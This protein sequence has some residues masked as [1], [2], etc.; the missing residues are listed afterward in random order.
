MANRIPLTIAIGDHAATAALKDGTVP[1]E[2]VDATFLSIKPQIA[3]FRRM[4]RDVEFDVCELAATTYV[5][6]RSFGAPFVALPTFLARRFHHGELLVRPDAGI[7]EPRDLEGRKAGVRA[8]SVTTGV[9]SRGVLIEEFGLHN[10]KVRWI[11]DDEEH[12][13]QLQLPPN[14]SQT[15]AGKS[16]AGMM[17]AN[18][19]QAGYSGNAGIGRVGNP[20]TDWKA[21]DATA[22][23]FYDELISDPAPLEAN[24]FLR[25]GIYPVHGTVV[26]KETLL[27]EY[28]RLATSLAEA[29]QASKQIWLEKLRSGAADSEQDRKYRDLSPVVGED[30]LPYGLDWNRPTIDALQ[31][32]SVKQGLIKQPLDLETLFHPVDQAIFGAPR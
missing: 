30:P 25:T 10:D 19:I 11:V 13:Q 24:W 28:P 15:P 2:G 3:A 21:A 22:D 20:T 23:Q 29:F 26:I 1:I 6:A 16:L 31:R 27:R 17:A 7:H 9:W 4:V 14:V 8:Y 12:V 18:E 32:I 5:I